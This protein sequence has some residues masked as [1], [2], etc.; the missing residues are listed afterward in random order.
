MPSDPIVHVIDDDDA[1]RDSL[2]F[3][4][5]TSGFPVQ[6]YASAVAF[7]DQIADAEPGCIVSDMRMPGLTGLDLLR[8]LRTRQVNWPVIVITGQGDVALA[9]ESIRAGAVDFIEKP[10]HHE[11][12]LGAVQSALTADDDIRE[13]EKAD[14][15][16]RLATLS[17]AEHQVLDA[18]TAGQA[19]TAIA[20]NLAM[21][22]RAVEIH[23]ASILTKMQARS[24]SHLVRMMLLTTL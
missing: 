12:L 15:R 16:D 22:P 19:N 8:H 4:L 5:E 9:V 1:A 20:I 10:Y 3:L 18:L 24:L 11:E 6:T 17:P 7:L 13:G 23:R 21:T 2:A 14:L